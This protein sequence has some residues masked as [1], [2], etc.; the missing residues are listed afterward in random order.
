MWVKATIIHNVS[1]SG[2]RGR[3][4][5]SPVTQIYIISLLDNVASS[6]DKA[7]FNFGRVLS[8]L[9][10]RSGIPL[11]RPARAFRVPSGLQFPF[12]E[13]LGGELLASKSPA[14][15]IDNLSETRLFGSEYSG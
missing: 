14:L 4:M 9:Y 5:A 10:D 1:R 13:D 7:N 3:S 11:V 2:S 8:I 6:L 15:G 12:E